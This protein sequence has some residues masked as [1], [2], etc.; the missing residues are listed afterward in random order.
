MKNGMRKVLAVFI[1]TALLLPL[2]TSA[3]SITVKAA[4]A[5]ALSTKQRSMVGI[6]STFTLTV[7]NLDNT[8]VKTKKWSSSN[9]KIATVNPT[10]GYVTAKAK[11]TTSINLKITYKDKKTSTLTCKVTVMIPAT[12]IVINNA[13]DTPDNNNRQLMQVGEKYDFNVDLTP[14]NTSAIVTY[15]IDNTNVATVDQNGVVTAVSPGFTILTATASLTAA[16]AAT[17]NINDK[18][19]IEVAAKSAKVKTAVITDSTTLTINFDSSVDAATVFD[20]NKKLLNVVEI[21]PKYDS[22]GNMANAV[23]TLTGTLSADAK[24]LTVNTTKIFN[25]TYNIHVSSA[26]ASTAGVALQNY[27]TDITYK[28]T[29]PPYF[30]GFTVDDSGLKASINFSEAMDFSGLTIVDAKLNTT[31]TAT[32]ALPATIALLKGKANYKP[33]ADY[34]SLIIDMSSIADYDKNKQFTVIMSG[35]KDLS[36]NYPAGYTISTTAGTDTTYKPQAALISIERTG[37]NTLTATFTRNIRVPGMVLLSNGESITNGTVDAKDPKKVNYTISST[38]ALLSGIQ[39]VS[40][41]MWDSYNVNPS[42]TTGRTFVAYDVN[43][44]ITSARPSINKFELKMETNS[45][46]DTYMLSLTYNKD[47]TLMSQTGILVASRIITSNNDIYSN[48]NISYTASAQGNIVT[49]ILNSGQF[50][51]AGQYT[52]TIP[53]GFVKDEYYNTNADESIQVVKTATASSVLAP[54]R[55]ITQSPV[56]PSVIYVTFADKLDETSAQA[57][58][59]YYIP[60]VVIT[61]A[62]LTANT[63]AGATV[64]LT[65]A[66]GSI[67]YTTIYPITIRNIAGYNNTYT[68]MAA[69]NNTISLTE[70]VGPSYTGINFTY[71]NTVTLTFSENVKGN[72]SFDVVQSGVGTANLA[73]SC[74]FT[75]NKVVILLTTTPVKGL[76][77]TIKA[78]ANNSITDN[79]GN[80]AVMPDITLTPTY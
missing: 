67:P 66:P 58:G 3:G 22:N 60:G 45:G 8:K 76:P 19:I 80:A 55:A 25:G 79:A 21:T 43:F 46:V 1:I 50:S 34:K 64:T 38:A 10:T 27:Y 29:I 77:L 26:I 72:P 9:S 41:A 48:R 23:G 13:T 11:G 7:K 78:T 68:A 24:V 35:I 52:I 71:P 39:K 17:S 57:L 62:E 61:K 20:K 56:N 42:D 36:G 73:Y 31:S 14:V 28:D 18:I 37:Y 4:A 70:N 44:T 74:S 51:E 69:Y 12:K 16:G 54:P 33:S 47:V 59:N 63:T 32:Q 49:V 75:D 15:S 6:G 65:L 53:S 2:L 30:T 40:V 5:P